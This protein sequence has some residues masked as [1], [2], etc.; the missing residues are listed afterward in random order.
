MTKKAALILTAGAILLVSLMGCSLTQTLARRLA[1]NPTSTRPPTR[2]PRPTYT[3]TPD[4]TP[5]PTVTPTPTDTP[6]PTD[7]ATPVPTDTATSIPPTDTPLP[8]NTPKPRPPTATFT[9]APPTDTPAPTFP[10][11]LKEQSDRRYTQTN[12]AFVII[13]VD[14]TDGKDVPLGGYKVI[15]D[16]SNGMHFVSAE[17]CYTYCKL[18]GIKGGYIKRANVEFSPGPF[19]DGSWTLYLVDKSGTQVSPTVTLSY[20]TDPSQRYWDFVWFVKK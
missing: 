6:I 14:I 1:A 18:S 10:F 4:W 9:P 15:G 11:S 2:T 5:T 19:I 16:S 3:P 17:S 8:T 12:N 7:T 20:S 13:L